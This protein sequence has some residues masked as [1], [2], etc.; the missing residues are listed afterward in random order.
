[1]KLYV[2]NLPFSA[3]EHEVRELFGQHGTV[4]EVNL[5]TDRQTGQLRGF[6]FVE[7]DDTEATAAMNAL[8]G[9][10]MGGRN[11]NVNEA[12]PRNDSRGG[13]GGR[14]DRW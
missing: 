14:R 12:R 8:N 5:I 3:T 1:M 4:H 10:E 9:T 6:G 13:G 7:M 11:L 2:G